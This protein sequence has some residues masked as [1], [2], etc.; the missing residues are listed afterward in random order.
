M[1]SFKAVSWVALIGGWAIVVVGCLILDKVPLAVGGGI[2]AVCTFIAWAF[3]LGWLYGLQRHLR[4]HFRRPLKKVVPLGKS[5]PAS[6]LVDVRRALAFLFADK[7]T[8]NQRC[9]GLFQHGDA[10]LNLM[11]NDSQHEP[12]KW[13]SVEAR[14]GHYETFPENGLYLLFYQG[15]P[16]AAYL[17]PS[18]TH[19]YQDDY[20]DAPAPSGTNLQVLAESLDDAREIVNYLFRVAATQSVYRG[21]MLHVTAPKFR[22]Q[23]PTITVAERAQVGL[24]RIVLPAPVLEVLDR[25]ISTRLAYHELLKRHGHSSKTGI[26]LHGPPGTG[27]T[28]MARHLIGSA[29]NH[30]AIVP[31]GMEA[32]TIREAFRLAAYL[33]PALVVIEDVDLLAE[34]RESNANVTG[35]QELM[36]EMDGL[37]TSAEAI[38]IMTTNRPEVL[39]PALA[40]RPGR[41]SQAISFPLPDTELRERLLKLFCNRAD[42][43]AVNLPHWVE[44]T[45]GASPAFLEELVKRAIIFAAQRSTPAGKETIALTDADFDAAIHELVVFGGTLTS[46]VLGFARQ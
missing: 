20:V 23:L 36:N 15:R 29:Q 38:V 5:V 1:P 37:G 19:Q 39:E 21:M 16:F 34:R 33:Q 42:V 3:F 44:R 13:L 30:T 9:F 41:V 4:A 28:L 26:L 45:D 14:D 22:G 2:S 43:S 46:K 6:R 32:E 25:T 11:T 10:L 31:M 27:K 7:G 12:M 24:Q 35:L 40:A 8:A 17:G 18:A